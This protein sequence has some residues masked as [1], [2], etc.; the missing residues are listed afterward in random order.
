MEG[1]AILSLC[2]LGPRRSS[3][4]AHYISLV[5]SVKKVIV[6][7]FSISYEMQVLFCF[8]DEKGEDV[9]IVIFIC[10]SCHLL[11]VN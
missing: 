2:L 4:T 9:L 11:L 10:F 3:V 7:D 5:D 8:G 1:L 6:I